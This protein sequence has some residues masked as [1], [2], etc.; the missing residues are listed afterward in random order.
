MG[1]LNHL[2]KYLPNFRTQT[3]Q[4][5]PSL[6]M[7]I[8]RKFVWGAAKQKAF[9]DTL[10]LISNITKRYDYNK[11]KNFNVKCDASRSIRGAAFEQEFQ[12]VLGFQYHLRLDF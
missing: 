2:Q 5:R 7:S 10:N 1:V 9:E 11:K 12:M 6:K 3:E 4:F 8:K